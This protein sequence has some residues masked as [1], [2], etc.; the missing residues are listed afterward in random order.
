MNRRQRE[1]L[2][3][4]LTASIDVNSTRTDLATI[5]VATQRKSA[6]DEA[7]DTH[8]AAVEKYNEE[9]R[10]FIEAEE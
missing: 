4:L 3:N 6:R 1:A 2:V 9:A 8:A 10:R 5:M 7:K